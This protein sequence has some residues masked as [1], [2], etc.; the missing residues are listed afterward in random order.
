M[1]SHPTIATLM[2]PSIFTA[3]PPKVPYAGNGQLV[4]ACILGI[5]AV[6]VLI[7]VAKVHPFL[8]LMLGSA[9]LGAVATMPPGDIVASFLAGFG[10]TAGSVGV[11]IAL[12]AMIGKLLEDSGGA[13]RIVSTMVGRVGAGGLPW[14]M[15]AIAA[16]LGLPLF[17]EVGV[18]QAD[19]GQRSRVRWHQA[20]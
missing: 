18:Q 5:L 1:I 14:A 10:S 2:V 7:T 6:V 16:I 11:L 20:V 3:D 8:S 15:A 13:N 19:R 4:A 12:G 17:F 9:V